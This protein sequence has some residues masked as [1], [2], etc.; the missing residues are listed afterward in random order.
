MLEKRRHN[1]KWS[2]KRAGCYIR[3]FMQTILTWCVRKHLSI[4]RVHFIGLIN[5]NPVTP[6]K[7]KRSPSPNSAGYEM[8]PI[9]N[10]QADNDLSYS[11]CVKARSEPIS[12]YEI[13]SRPSLDILTAESQ[14]WHRDCSD[15][16]TFQ[17][18]CSRRNLPRAAVGAAVVAA[19]RV[20]SKGLNEAP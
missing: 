18:N 5:C 20:T 12:V 10:V 4:C 15:P 7:K 16:D 2:R 9:E 11:P 6:P 19:S 17:V 13:S 3:N 1:E 14:T 8:A